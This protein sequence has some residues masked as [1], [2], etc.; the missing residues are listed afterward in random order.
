MGLYDRQYSREDDEPR[1]FQIGEQSMATLLVIANVA[2][3]VIDMFT[4]R[5]L[6]QVLQLNS[7]AWQRPWQLYQLITY[8]FAH[9]NVN[10]ILFNMFGLYSFGRPIEQRYGRNEFLA[11][12]LAAA[13]FGGVV[14]LLH[15][16]IDPTGGYVLGASGAVTAIVI[17]FA[18]NFP[19]ETILVMFILPM[20]A[21][22]AAILFVLV[23]MFGIG[24]G[25]AHDVHLAG[26]GF[27]LMYFQFHWRLVD[28][29]VNVD[30]SKWLKR[31]PRLRVFKQ[32]D[33]AEA[34]AKIDDILAKISEQGTES[35]TK[36]ERK[37]LEAAS[38]R[39]QNK[40]QQ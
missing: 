11:F 8:A 26:A 19:N 13:L 17:L 18:L 24:S 15:Q 9:G 3:F 14:W 37:A 40:R 35:L 1:G 16:A 21:W 23:D 28:H 25:I 6:A 12:Y 36:A 29:W 31:R 38:R 39:Y 30:P 34:D 5:R 27:A 10:H 7:D 33:P 22:V 2:V 32:P 4:E 20:K